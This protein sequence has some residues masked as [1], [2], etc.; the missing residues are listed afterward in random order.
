MAD[1][2]LKKDKIPFLLDGDSALNVHLA[3]ADPTKKLPENTADLFSLGFKGGAAKP[4][5]V[6]G[7]DNV[8]LGVDAEAGASLSPYWASSGDRLKALETYGLMDYFDGGK[9]AGRLLLVLALGAKADAELAG[10]FKYSALSAG[11]SLKAGADAAY[12]LVRSFPADTPAIDLVPR[13]FKSFRLPTDVNGPLAEDELIVFEYGGYLNFAASV[14]AGYELSGSKGFAFNKDKGVGSD[15]VDVSGLDFVEKYSFS[16]VAKLGFTAGVAGRFRVEV[17]PG[18][19]EGWA[20]VVVR[21]SRSKTF[22]IAADVEANASFESEGLP[23]SSDEFV[24]ALVGV[25]SKNWLNLFNRVKDLSDFDTLKLHLDKLAQAFIE[26]YTGKA[27]EE[28]ADKTKLDEALALVR[29]AARQYTEAGD[30]AVTLFDKYF[31]AAAGVVDAKLTEALD[32]IR[33][34]PS[35]DDI[36]AKINDKLGDPRL[37]DTLWAVVGQ[38]TDGDA[39]NWMLGKVKIKDALVDSLQELK[40]R[41]DKA[42]A[43]ARDAAHAEIRRL[44]ALAKSK[45]PFDPLVGE[46]AGLDAAKLKQLADKRLVGFVERLIGSSI[47]KLK[48]SEVGAAVTKFHKVLVAVDEFKEKV[49]GKDGLAAKALNS[50]YKLKLHAEYKRASENNALLDVEFDLNRD[51]GRALMRKAG[52]GDF[53]GVIKGYDAGVVKLN[54]GVLTHKATRETSLA[55]NVSGWHLNWNYT[56]LDRIITE[57]EQH[58]S[59]GPKGTLDVLTNID[60]TKEKDVRR[61][62]ERVYTNMMLR[63]VGESHGVLEAN[64]AGNA[65]LVNSLTGMEASYKL[66]FEDDKTKPEEL[67]RYLSFADEFGV[68]ATDKEALDA[69]TPYLT[70][71]DGNVGKAEVTYNATF[72][73]DGLRS[74]FAEVFSPVDEQFLRKTARRIVLANYMSRGGALTS[75]GW[76]YWTDDLYKKWKQ[77]GPNFLNHSA[78]TVDDVPEIEGVRTPKQA[79]IFKNNGGVQIVYTLYSIEESLIKGM[80]ALSILARSGEKL[81]PREFEKRL[82]DFGKALKLY[83]SFDEGDNTVFAMFDALIKRNAGGKPYLES[84]LEVKITQDDETTTKVLVS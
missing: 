32:F 25:K 66:L 51:A 30:R 24:S 15:E 83:D 38:L 4:F 67:A 55:V 68:A 11:A 49:F 82:A 9:H 18:S 70:V 63:F 61:Q 41:A 56:S 23:E 57:T 48:D 20:R 3:V 27:F 12:A 14:A 79:V 53:F 1:I 76:A 17:R 29:R 74:L 46:L 13:F 45:F 73:E 28:L 50:S 71:K 59:P 62:R 54:E 69:V 77:E 40:A 36:K 44:V 60:L 42:I 22:S 19:S 75:M 10:K 34:A 81:D 84:S 78:W 26:E 80:R 43:L 35:W 58:I 7:G 31:D 21:K 2:N 37:S 16:L 6:G 47:D 33:D 72:T 39:L 65:Y 52:R 64:E 5:S 8:T